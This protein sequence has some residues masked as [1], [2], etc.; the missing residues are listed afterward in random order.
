MKAI[1][2]DSNNAGIYR[3]ISSGKQSIGK[4]I[5]EAVD[6]IC[7]KLEKDEPNTII[8]VQEFQGDEFFSDEQIRR[9]SELME[10]WKIAR[11]SGRTL[12]A[13]NQEELE[14]LIGIELEASGKRVEK[15][16]T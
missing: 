13:E 14:N 4:T 6:S 15:F 2:I 8:Y 16:F 1:V 11:D 10:K 12:S 3:A 9:L 7:S 5:G